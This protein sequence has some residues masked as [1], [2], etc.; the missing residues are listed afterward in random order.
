[1]WDFIVKLLE[2]LDYITGQTC[3]SILIIVNKFTK[4]GYFIIYKKSML[5]EKLL[6]VYIKEVFARY[7]VLIKIILDK[8]VKFILIF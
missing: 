7:R 3:N 6:K 8:D 1:M 2:L 4:C 5:A